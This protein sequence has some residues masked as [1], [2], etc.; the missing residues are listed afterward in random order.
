MRKSVF[1]LLLLLLLVCF[2]PAGAFSGGDAFGH[3]EKILSFGPRPSGSQSLAKVR[4]YMTAH[5]KSQGLSVRE[6]SFS[7][8]TP[9]GRVPMT[10]LSAL[11]KGKGRGRVILAAHYESK[12]YGDMK[13][14]GANDNA[15][16][17]AV[18]LA[19]AGVLK[20]RAYSFDVELLFLDGEESFGVWS[21]KD[22][23][24]GSRHYVK[25]RDLSD[26]RAMILLDMVGK[27]ELAIDFEQYS[28]PWLRRV[29]AEA[30]KAEGL[31]S[32]LS[33]RGGYIEDDHIPF[34]KAGVP[35]VD[36]I[37][38]NYR[39]WHTAQDT[40]DK[41]DAASLYRSGRIVLRMLHIIN[42]RVQ[43]GPIK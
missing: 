5:L 41:L 18:L 20:Q 27:K 19:L 9:V 3:A 12:Y 10:N 37:D 2:C 17:T 38:F 13:F 11:I 23:L 7:A 30:A 25:N 26:V 14:V 16:G 36:L 33:G 15:S 39:H 8:E 29:L 40:V 28:T 6:D 42:R 34:L 35:A 4:K 1:L 31:E 22:S 32:C 43:D 21:E 24:Y